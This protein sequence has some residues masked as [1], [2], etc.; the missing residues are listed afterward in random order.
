MRKKHDESRD[1]RLI[2]R[3]C[4]VDVGNHTIRANKNTTIG[5][6]T[7]GRIDFL[8]HKGWYF[9]WD[10]S[11]GVTNPRLADAYFGTLKDIKREAKAPKL[12]NKRR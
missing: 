11:V 5:I 1:L 6:R 9:F 7:W 2:A 8:Y 4:K 12:T 10:N 3:I